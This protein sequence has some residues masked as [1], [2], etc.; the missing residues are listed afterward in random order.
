MDEQ[1]KQA[2]LFVYSDLTK[3][4]VCEKLSGVLTFNHAF[5]HLLI[6]SR[7]V[8][9]LPNVTFLLTSLYLILITQ[10]FV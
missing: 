5:Y 10:P 1:A 2:I 9:L 3:N 4:K 7:N 6:G 8:R